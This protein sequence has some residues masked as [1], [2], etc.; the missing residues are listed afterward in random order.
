MEIKST[1]Y[2]NMHLKIR[3]AMTQEEVTEKSRKMVRI[4]LTSEWY[5]QA[6]EVFVYSPIGKEADCRGLIEQA[7]RDGK[8]VAFPRVESE[9][10][11]NFYYVD[12]YEDLAE[13]SFHVA[14]P[15]MG[16]RPAVPDN[17]PVLVPGSVFDRYGNR[18]G[19]GKGYYDRFFA[20]CPKLKRIGL[21]FEN[22]IEEEIPV[23]KY[24]VK[25]HEIYTERETVIP[26][27]K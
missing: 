16:C 18:Y 4:L 14:E 8:R 23:G 2:R 11:M 19:Y 5:R 20:R 27:L 7:W 17:Q 12:C 15:K 10:R 1:N 9:N 24:D 3:N 21:C 26:V 22:Q 6:A 13:G 25:M